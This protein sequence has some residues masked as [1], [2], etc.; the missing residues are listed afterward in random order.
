MARNF[1][2]SEREWQKIKPLLPVFRGGKPRLNDRLIISGILLSLST[3][4]PWRELPAIYGSPNTLMSRYNRWKKDGTLDRICRALKF[5]PMSDYRR[6]C[7]Q[8]FGTYQRQGFKRDGFNPWLWRAEQRTD[9][10]K[11]MK[12]IARDEDTRP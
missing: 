1:Y 4:C 8:G 3:A 6:H 5:E 9:M 12:M 11:L 10:G 2:L 7:R